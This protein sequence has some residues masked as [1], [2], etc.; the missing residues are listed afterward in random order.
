MS[1]AATAA[2]YL[3]ARGRL[4]GAGLDGHV[5]AERS[6]HAAESQPA[7][8]LEPKSAPCRDESPPVKE[9]STPR[10]EHRKRRSYALPSTA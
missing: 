2:G 3:Y 9:A 6:H 5:D 10:I 7:G 1:A 8:R 4:S